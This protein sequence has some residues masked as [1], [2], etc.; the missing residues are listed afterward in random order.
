MRL[1]NNFRTN[2]CR[3]K[4]CWAIPITSYSLTILAEVKFFGP[5][6]L[7]Q[8]VWAELIAIL[9]NVLI[10]NDSWQKKIKN[11][12]KKWIIGFEIVGR[13]RFCLSRPIFLAEDHF[14]RNVFETIWLQ[15]LFYCSPNGS[16]WFASLRALPSFD[17]ASFHP[18]D[19]TPIDAFMRRLSLC[20]IKNLTCW[21]RFKEM[22]QCIRIKYDSWQYTMDVLGL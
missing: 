3:T 8:N 20:G 15:N 12:T 6:F 4:Q 16:G 2:S 22:S 21:S 7:G 1:Y 5:K 13:L 19:F 14:Q 18:N 10:F 11:W 9:R 17:A